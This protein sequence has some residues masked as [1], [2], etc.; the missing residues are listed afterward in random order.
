MLE[1]TKPPAE[2]LK[3]L[4]TAPNIYLVLSPDLY[5]L[6]A[7]DL[8]FKATEST[9]K[10]I[11]GKHI[12]EAFPAN[13]DLPDADGVQ[14]INASLQE[15]LRTKKPHYMRIQRYDVPDISNP[16]EF[17]QRYWDP[18][19]TPVL[20]DNGNISYIIQLAANVTDKVLTEQALEKSRSQEQESLAHV[21]ELNE[22][23]ISANNQLRQT[24]GNL[25]TLNAGLEEIVHS[26]TKELAIS[27]AKF[28][29]LIMQNP[30]AMQVYR[31]DDMTF[32]INNDAMLQFLGKTAEINGKT[33]FEGVPEIMG[34][35]IVDSL[36]HVYHTGEQ[37]DITA[38]PVMIHRNGQ[39]E[40]G[41]YNVSYRALYYDSKITGVLGIAIDVTAQVIARQ[42]LEESEE[43]LKV[44]IATGRMGTWSIELDTMQIT[45]SDFVKDLLGIPADEPATMARIMQAINLEYHTDINNAL[46]DAADNHQASDIE[47]AIRNLQTNEQKWVRA[48]GRVF[49]GLYGKSAQFTGMFIDITE[50]KKDEQ[51]KNDFIGMVSHELKTPLTSLKAYLQVLEIKAQ[52][53]DDTFVMNA[54]VKSNNQ[55][56]KMTTMING[57]LNV[58]RLESGKIHISIQRFDM[59]GLVKE[60][61]DESIATIASHKVIF[62][63][64]DELFVNADRDKIGQ[65]INNLISN[66]VKYSPQGSTIHVAC[67]VADKRARVCVKDE[68]MGISAKDIDKLF[69]RYYRVNNNT[70]IS[71]F[72]IGLYLSAEII[73]RHKGKIWAN[74][75]IGK[76]STFCFS[77]PFN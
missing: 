41:Y 39:D 19:H 27:E 75:E 65:V 33:L 9:R 8:Y 11:V 2:I 47:Y 23:L 42:A 76:G 58:S 35:P 56:N 72:G 55:V 52:K 24:Q 45:M 4:E 29:S 64:V 66:A 73:N 12:F 70:N 48:T 17:I 7:S 21:K 71:G 43:K 26:R 15:V 40:H 54:L 18:S 46:K 36:Y 68:G 53:N 30:I 13:P 34:Q 3:A 28:K 50:Q 49:P 1:T 74:S 69:D 22:A 62:S 57:F 20:D 63:P 32:E 37:L 60:V 5:I 31:G 61:E 10:A 44:A 51:R 59:A 77:I 67:Q 25:H 16:G 14:N 6:T 38:I